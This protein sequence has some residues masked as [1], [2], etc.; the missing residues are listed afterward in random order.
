[1][2]LNTRPL[3]RVIRMRKMC[4]VVASVLQALL[5]KGI[6]PANACQGALSRYNAAEAGVA[7]TRSVNGITCR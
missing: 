3:N 7:Q 2:T 5:T 4:S 6:Q 1:V